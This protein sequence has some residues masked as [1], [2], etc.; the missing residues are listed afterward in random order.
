M[1]DLAVH[2][3]HPRLHRQMLAVLVEAI[4]RGDYQPGELL[5]REVDLV[6][7][8]GVSRGVVREAIRG[9]EERDLISVRHGHGAI[10]RSQTEWDVL[11]ADILPT[12]L[13]GPA[14][15][16]ILGEVIE[17]R[18]ILE[19]EAAG[20]AA[21][22]A[23]PEDVERIRGALGAMEGLASPSTPSSD[24]DEFLEADMAFHETVIAATGNRALRR[25]VAPIHQSLLEARRPLARP[26][27]RVTR[28]VP[29]HVAVLQAIESH[30][31]D[32]ARTAMQTV[33]VTITDYLSEYADAA[34]APGRRGGKR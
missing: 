22:R 1:T 18:R 9:L 8:F 19:V 17:A 29:E 30:D 3:T 25:I 15:V 6:D 14:S 32:G 28:A 33:F 23:T 13:L 5:P 21:A 34:Q 10:V 20:L 2:L 16:D 11:A 7:K 26:E 4:L 24:Q 27:Y 31:V 12:L